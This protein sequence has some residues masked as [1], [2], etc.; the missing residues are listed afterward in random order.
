MKYRIQG[1]D[2]E[3]WV[4]S[5]KVWWGWRFIGARFYLDLALKLLPFW[6]G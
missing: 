4:V 3:G 6:R 1:S 5:E 2:G